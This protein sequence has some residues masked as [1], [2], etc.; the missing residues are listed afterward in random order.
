MKYFVFVSALLLSQL[1]FAEVRVTSQFGFSANLPDGWFVISPRTIAK[2]NKNETAQSLGISGS[3]ESAVLD[4]ILDR[5]KGGNIEFYYDNKYVR[6]DFKNHVSAQL[7]PPLQFNSMQ[8]VSEQCKALPAELNQLF[9]ESVSLISCQLINAGGWP[10]FHHAYTVES[11]SLT[12][13]NETVHVNQ[14]YSMIFV[15]GSG[16]GADG[17]H[18]VRAAQQALIEAIINHLKGQSAKK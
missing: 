18:R 15:G 9:G 4:E 6:K 5:V 17:L 11:Q 8:E 1:S 16:N 13:I 7:G 12:I 2:A 14:N 3:V 10:V